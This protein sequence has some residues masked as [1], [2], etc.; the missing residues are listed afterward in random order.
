[1]IKALHIKRSFGSNFKSFFT[2][3][4]KWEHR[5]TCSNTSLIKAFFKYCT[6]RT[7]DSREIFVK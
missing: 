4:Y 7:L 5:S 6:M 3:G 2:F 1:M